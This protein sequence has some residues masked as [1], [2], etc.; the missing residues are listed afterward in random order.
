MTRINKKILIYLVAGLLV[1]NLALLIYFLF[2]PPP[3]KLV[4]SE[5]LKKLVESENLKIIFLDV[6]QGDATLIQTSNQQ[7]ILIDGGPDKGII[8]KL[9]QYLPFYQRRIDL[10]I[11]TH[12][13]PDH[14]NGLIEVLNR[15]QVKSFL[16]N[17]VFD[18]SIDYQN[19]LRKID[20]KGIKKEIAW[21]KGRINFQDGYLEFLFPLENLTGK[22]FKNDNEA[23]IVLKLIVGQIKI[24]LTGDATKA[25]EKQLIKENIDLSAD[26]LKVAHHGSRDS[27]GL[28]FLEKVQ[29]KYAVISVGKN[30]KF[31]HPTLRVLKNLKKIGA[32]ILRTDELG[33]IIFEINSVS[34][35][36][37]TSK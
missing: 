18:E 19:F 28:E 2:I 3:P 17:G 5:N 24:L 23:S 37:R 9:D 30:N 27:T 4:E 21:Q 32:K 1:I 8:Y 16:F 11:L 13:D 22:S 20:E 14:L 26:I 36:L 6:G 35:N 29:P 15:Y 33:D 34:L 12:P 10:M 7:N 25:V 31:G